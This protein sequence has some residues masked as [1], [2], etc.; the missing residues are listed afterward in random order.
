MKYRLLF[1]SV[2][3]VAF[4][5]AADDPKKPVVPKGEPAYQR[6]TEGWRFGCW[7]Y[8]DSKAV[9][10]RLFGKDGEL[11]GKRDGETI[12]TGFG[13]LVW[14][15]H[16]SPGKPPVKSTGWLFIESFSG[17]PFI[18]DRYDTKTGELPP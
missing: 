13:T 10:G 18:R 6:Q 3:F 8:K 12:E 15:G 2:L 14:R 16:F 17:P 5:G 11:F 4:A 1:V 9:H 7:I